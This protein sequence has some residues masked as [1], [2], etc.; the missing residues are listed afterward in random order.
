MSVYSFQPKNFYLY[1]VNI[2]SIVKDYT[3]E[4]DLQTTEQAETRISFTVSDI[5]NTD[6]AGNIFLGKEV[7]DLRPEFTEKEWKKKRSIEL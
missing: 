1:G 3:I 4:I 2:S 5:P 6:E 7:K